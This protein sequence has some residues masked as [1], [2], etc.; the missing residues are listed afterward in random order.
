MASDCQPQAAGT[1]VRL[2]FNGYFSAGRDATYPAE[3]H[4]NRLSWLDN[5]RL[6]R[7]Q[8]LGDG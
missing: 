2:I 7:K 1:D 6:E 8:P 4:P 3:K 5:S